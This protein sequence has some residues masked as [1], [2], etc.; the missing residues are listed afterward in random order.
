MPTPVDLQS[1]SLYFGSAGVKTIII[2]L[3]T[4]TSEITPEPSSH[5]LPSNNSGSHR[6]IIIVGCVVGLM[7]GLV[8]MGILVYKCQKQRRQKAHPYVKPTDTKGSDATART[9]HWSSRF[10][11]ELEGHCF[12]SRR[13]V[14]ILRYPVELEAGTEFQA[15][16]RPSYGTNTVGIGGGTCHDQSK[17]DGAPPIHPPAPGWN[18]YNRQSLGA[19]ELDS[20]PVTSFVE[21]KVRGQMFIADWTSKF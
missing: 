5:I 1:T 9:K 4:S 6:T 20:T 16:A 15:G 8:G 3:T 2:S 19:V 18:A 21:R 13:S 12:N 7:L 10:L 17:W 14:A 11:S